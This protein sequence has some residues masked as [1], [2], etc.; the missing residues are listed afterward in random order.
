MPDPECHIRF[1]NNPYGVYLAGQ[2]L[3]GQV[4][5][6]LTEV[7]NVVGVSLRLDGLTEIEWS[8]EIESAAGQPGRKTTRYYGQQTLLNSTS[9]LCGSSVGPVRDLAIGTHTYHFSCELPAHLPTSFEGYHARIRYTAK[10][11]LHRTKA[12]T[13]PIGQTSFTVLRHLNLNEHAAV[14]VLPTKS[15]LTKVFCCGPCS[16]EPLYI[17]A[18]IP[19]CGYIPGQTIVIKIDAV[20]RSR[21]RVIEFRIKL[22]QKLCYASQHP[23]VE[24]RSDAL[25]VA[26]SRCSGVTSGEVVKHQQNLLIPALPPTYTDG[27][28]VFSIN[29]E[30][31]VEARVTGPNISP[32]LAMPI[33]IGTIALEASM[34]KEKLKPLTKPSW[35][36]FSSQHTDIIGTRIPLTNIARRSQAGLEDIPNGSSNVRLHYIVHRKSDEMCEEN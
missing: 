9:F 23:T 2:I 11:S 17:S 6:R 20:N 7:L 30:L 5:L 8:E 1:D 18:Q 25:V 26:E 31:E 10:V 14:L 4:E 29:Y 21:T 13:D 34:P 16:S 3:A 33:T 15:E 12:R 22:I 19:R 24:N 27:S 32:R 35:D 28:P 36:P